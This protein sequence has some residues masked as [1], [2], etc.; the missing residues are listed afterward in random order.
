M[1]RYNF[2]KIKSEMKKENIKFETNSDTE[3]LIK[4]IY[5]KGLRPE[6]KQN[7]KIKFRLVGRERYPAKT[8]ST[9]SANLAVKYLPSGSQFIEHGTYYS[10]K[11]AVT[12]DVIIPFGSGSLVSCDTDG[13]FFNVW[14]N[15]LQTERYYK[16]ELYF[17]SN[18]NQ[19]YIMYV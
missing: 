12:E 2:N 16:F 9:T 8:Y 15:G 10:V 4:L 7:S 13:N 3:V 19:I 1:L 17:K 14:M 5:F 6:Y 11:D 18:K